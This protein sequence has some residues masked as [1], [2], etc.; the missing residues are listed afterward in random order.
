[1]V[2]NLSAATRATI[3]DT[4]PAHW[5][6]RHFEPWSEIV[7]ASTHNRA[8]GFVAGTLLA[9]ALAG[10]LAAQR[11]ATSASDATASATRTAQAFLASLN[12]EQRARVALPYNDPKKKA[13]HN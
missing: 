6:R 10:G 11:V 4:R 8:L 1:M 5:S 13:W 9:T 7:F 2:R 12:A 3:R